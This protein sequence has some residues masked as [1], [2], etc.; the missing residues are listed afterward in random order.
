MTSARIAGAPISWGVCEVPDWGHQLPAER[1][2]AEMRALGLEATEFG[3]PGFLPKEP[4]ALAARLAD[5]GMRGV[6]GFLPVVAHDP[7][8]DPVPEV[9]AFIDACLAADAGVVV[10]AAGT[11]LDGYDTRPVLDER[12]WTTLLTTLDR[13]DRRATE[14]GVVVAL[15]PHVGT[16][17]EAREEVE[18][19]L[20]GST[21]GLCVDTGHLLVG[22]TD[23]VALTR[24]HVDRVRHVHL[25]DVDGDLA[26]QVLA[27]TRGFADAVR[28]GLWV[29]LGRGSVD[30]AAMIRTLHDAG[31]DGWY[32][33]EQDVMLDGE[34]AGEGPVADV[35]ESL[36][37]VRGALA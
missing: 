23:P 2:L 32:V 1:V 22:G 19:V 12:G 9:D 24:D 36:D 25:K 27:G 30:V 37:Y 16:M 29:A 26:D 28:A 8:H 13:I 7:D 21:V 14:R 5:Y 6:G 11:G 15:H 33:L 31:Y 3:P 18:R 17:V 10:L 35:R 4:E 20:A 34:P